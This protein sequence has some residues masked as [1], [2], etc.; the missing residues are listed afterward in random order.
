MRLD[1]YLK[2]ARIL[3]RRTAANELAAN[4]RVS[5]NGKKAKPS[6]RVEVGDE[7]EVY[8]GNRYLKVRVLSLET[9]AKKAEAPSMYEVLEESVR[10][11]WEEE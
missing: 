8:F 3:K 1:K 9:S 10:K 7:V 5:L 6:A 4:G 11:D 2:T